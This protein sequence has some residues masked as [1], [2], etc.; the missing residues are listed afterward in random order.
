MEE[1]GNRVVGVRRGKIETI[2]WTV[3]GD[4]VIDCVRGV[5]K[6]DWVTRPNC[7]NFPARTVNSGAVNVGW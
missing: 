5:M 3:I 6:G 2:K 7:N 4:R 1:C